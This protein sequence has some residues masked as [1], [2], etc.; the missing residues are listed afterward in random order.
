MA[1]DTP[2]IE[3]RFRERIGTRYAKRLR[4]QGRLP[5]VIYGHGAAPQSV[6]VDEKEILHAL[7]LG[8]HV[9]NVTIEGKPETCLVKELQ[10]Y[11]EDCP[12]FP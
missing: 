3:A 10:V 1:H 9:F 7:H 4:D 5:A 11:R 8:A 6:S 12:S 2:T